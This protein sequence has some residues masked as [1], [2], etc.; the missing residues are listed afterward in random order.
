MLLI[1]KF[2]SEVTPESAED[3]ELS[4]SGTLAENVPYTFRELI[5]LLREHSNPSCSHGRVS[6]LTWFSTGF[7]VDDYAT[8]T[9]CEQSI[10]YSRDNLPR[11]A[12]Y[13]CKAIRYV[14]G[15]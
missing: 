6:I 5:D 7:R 4:D 8:G 3:G 2:F 9:E 15:D 12:K 10:H 1:N 13:W 11:S 14:Y